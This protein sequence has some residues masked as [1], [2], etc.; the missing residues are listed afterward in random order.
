MISLP[1][2]LCALSQPMVFGLP[3]ALNPILSIPMLVSPSVTLLLGHPAMATGLVPYMIGTSIP[4]GTPILFS[5]F[6]AY[7]SWKGVALQIV[8]ILISTAIYYPFFKICDNQ[9]LKAE[10]ESHN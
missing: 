4:T 8:L 3:M 6:I 10:K 7:G 1:A 2:G 5:G 9:E